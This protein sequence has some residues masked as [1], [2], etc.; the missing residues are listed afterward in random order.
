MARWFRPPATSR[1]LSATD[2]ISCATRQLRDSLIPK[3]ST[4][5]YDG[6]WFAPEREALQALVTETQR[7]VTGVVRLKLYKGN[8]IIAGRK[9]PKSLYDPQIATMETVASTYDQGD[10][11]GFIR[12]NTLRLKVRAAL[13][14]KGKGD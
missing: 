12:L 14:T 11:T 10:A 8:I 13:K 6:F 7:D 2:K 9:S 1:F 4:L 3:Y 5:V